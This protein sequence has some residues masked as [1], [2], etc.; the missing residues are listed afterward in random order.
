MIKL[1]FCCSSIFFGEI[2]LTKANYWMKE[3]VILKF[4]VHIN[5]SGKNLGV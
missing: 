4:F 5:F 1:S 2:A 3:L